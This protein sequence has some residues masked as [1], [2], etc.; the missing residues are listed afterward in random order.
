MTL[1]DIRCV[2]AAEFKT[3]F[4]EY[5]VAAQHEPIGITNH[6]RTSVVLLSA[7]EFERLK[8]LDSRRAVYVAEIGDED[9]SR[10]MDDSDIPETSRQAQRALDSET[11][12]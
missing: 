11:T 1:K 5:R 9:W 10:I 7:T 12:S 4:G 8:S 6:G 3:H 2:P